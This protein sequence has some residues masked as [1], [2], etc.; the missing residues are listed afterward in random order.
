[1]EFLKKIKNELPDNDMSFFFFW[2]SCGFE[3]CYQFHP[4]DPAVK[5]GTKRAKAEENTI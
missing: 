5:T 3:A 1:M 4:C 2:K